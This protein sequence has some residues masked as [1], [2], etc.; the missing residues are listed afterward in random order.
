MKL[1][2][3][4]LHNLNVQTMYQKANTKAQWALL[5][6]IIKGGHAQDGVFI[7]AFNLLHSIENCKG[8]VVYGLSFE[9]DDKTAMTIIQ[10]VEEAMAGKY[11]Y[12]AFKRKEIRR[13]LRQFKKIKR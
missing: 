5:G 6:Y 12:A 10:I 1:I 13:I 11:N 9:T 7:G 4:G 2:R 3:V 8:K